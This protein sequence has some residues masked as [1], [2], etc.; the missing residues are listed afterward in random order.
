MGRWFWLALDWNDF[1]AGRSSMEI[2]DAWW[3]VVR[4]G[5]EIFSPDSFSP[6]LRKMWSHFRMVGRPA[7]IMCRP[8][9]TR[10]DHL[11]R[12][13]KKPRG[14]RNEKRPS[15]SHQDPSATKI[16]PTEYYTDPH[17]ARR[18]IMFVMAG[19]CRIYRRPRQL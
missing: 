1:S 18:I 4:R 3:S 8:V 17:L 12:W 2:C 11:L 6:T 16:M 5:V 19:C 15:R 10:R 7:I 14:G 9:G 13:N